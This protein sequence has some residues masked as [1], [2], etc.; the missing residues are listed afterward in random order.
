MGKNIYQSGPEQSTQQPESVQ[1]TQRVVVD[2]LVSILTEV[3]KQVVGTTPEPLAAP[4]REVITNLQQIKDALVPKPASQQPGQ[5][6]QSPT[7]QTPAQA[8]SP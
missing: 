4:S 8:P 3:K 6:T 1:T 5:L 7:Q 2:L